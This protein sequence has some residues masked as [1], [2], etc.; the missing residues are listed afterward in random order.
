MLKFLDPDNLKG[1]LVYASLYIATYEAFKDY[2]IEV[3]RDFYNLGARAGSVESTYE[4][5]VLARHKDILRASLFWFKENGAISQ[6][7]VDDFYD[8]RM[9]RNK[10]AHE[11]MNLLFDGLQDELPGKLERVIQIRVKIEKWWILNID[12]PDPEE[13]GL[14]RAIKEDDITTSSE[15]FY[16]LVTD[17]LSDDEKRSTYYRDEL[18]ARLKK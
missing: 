5:D 7:D 4:T 8:L 9:Y 16:Q 3:L 13:F 1:N 14:D 6:K 12:E 17:M 18:K 10:L 11:L 2:V 15:I